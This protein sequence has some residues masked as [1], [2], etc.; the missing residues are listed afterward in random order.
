MIV[1]LPGHAWD[2]GPAAGSPA[3]ACSQL[4]RGSHS[5]A[6]TRPPPC[7]PRCLD[8]P[9]DTVSPAPVLHDTW[10]PITPATVPVLP[11][12]RVPGIPQNAGTGLHQCP[13][14]LLA[15]PSR[16]CLYL[17]IGSSTDSLFVFWAPAPWP[18]STNMFSQDAQDSHI[19][20]GPHDPKST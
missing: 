5:P 18:C 16:C 15:L 14:C 2:R 12:I 13:S 11:E 17:E 19:G 1:L 7:L 6:H 4:P 20:S 3:Q 9:A 8:V 10:V